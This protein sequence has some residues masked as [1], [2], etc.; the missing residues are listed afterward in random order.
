MLPSLFLFPD[1]NHQMSM[2][3]TAVI[4]LSLFFPLYCLVIFIGLSDCFT[5]IFL[6]TAFKNKSF[7]ITVKKITQNSLYVLPTPHLKKN[8]INKIIFS[9][10]FLCRTYGCLSK[11]VKY[12]DETYITLINTYM[13]NL[14]SEINAMLQV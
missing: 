12:I 8:I 10:Q 14:W 4:F 3:A 7:S 11:L 9:I 1:K 6:R 5:H 2:N 13:Y